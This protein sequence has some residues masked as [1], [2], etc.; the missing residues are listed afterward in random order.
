MKVNGNINIE[1]E[2]I[3]KFNLLSREGQL[4]II[5]LASTLPRSEPEGSASDRQKAPAL[6]S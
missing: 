6:H 1:D 3:K 4:K 2:I 5:A